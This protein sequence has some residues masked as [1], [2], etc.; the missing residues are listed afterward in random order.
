MRTAWLMSVELL[1]DEVLTTTTRLA[2][3]IAFD[4]AAAK[5]GWLDNGSAT[6]VAR[7]EAYLTWSALTRDGQVTASFSE[8]L[9][10][11]SQIT[12]RPKKAPDPTRPA[13]PAE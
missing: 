10:Q 6:G 12:S 4:D 5:N 13:P 1:T 11:V 7:W 3:Q 9:A 8:F 2:D